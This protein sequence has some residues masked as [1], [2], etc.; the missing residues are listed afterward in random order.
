MMRHMW[1][2]GW[3]T[4]ATR[5]GSGDTPCALVSLR[6]ARK[7]AADLRGKGKGGGR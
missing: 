3:V 7:I 5:G 4:E 1:G 6:E 2:Q